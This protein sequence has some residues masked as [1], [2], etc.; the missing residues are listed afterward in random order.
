MF[1]ALEKALGTEMTS[2][3]SFEATEVSA[4][5]KWEVKIDSL[6]L[7]SNQKSSPNPED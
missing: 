1:L 4:T 5:V 3:M 2:P 6:H 7:T